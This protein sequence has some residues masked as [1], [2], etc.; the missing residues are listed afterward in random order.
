MKNAMLRIENRGSLPLIA[1]TSSNDKG[2]LAAV[3]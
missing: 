2:P 1:V 3:E